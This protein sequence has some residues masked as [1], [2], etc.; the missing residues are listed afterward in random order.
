MDVRE[1]ELIEYVKPILKEQ[2]FRKKAKRWTKITE[3]FTYIFFIQGSV[4][5][6]DNYYVRPGVIINDLQ[7][8]PLLVYGHFFINIPVTTK[9]EIIEKAEAFFSQWSSIEYLKKTVA[10]FVAWEKRN[11]A[12]KRRAGEADYETAP[13]PAYE[14]FSLTDEAKEEILKL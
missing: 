9:E 11:P 3:H 7:A 5:D 6:K 2:G 14:L 10:D 13:V 8:E 12:E 1:E 4:Y